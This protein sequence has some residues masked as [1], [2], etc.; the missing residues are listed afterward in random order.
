[1]TE[2]FRAAHQKLHN[3][4]NSAGALK[5]EISRKEKSSA[6]MRSKMLGQKSRKSLEAS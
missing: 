1:M 3:E 2:I 4:M 5:G 6:W